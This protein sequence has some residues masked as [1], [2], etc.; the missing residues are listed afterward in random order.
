MA[1]QLCVSKLDESLHSAGTTVFTIEGPSDRSHLHNTLEEA[2]TSG[3]FTDITLIAKGDTLK[4]HRL[5]LK[6][7]CKN[8]V[9]QLKSTSREIELDLDSNILMHVISYVYTNVAKIPKED[10]RAVAMAAKNMGVYDLWKKCL[11]THLSSLVI[12][13]DNCFDMWLQALEVSDDNII[14]SVKTF[15]LENF[16]KLQRSS[17]FR[18]LPYKLL[19]DYITDNDL[20]ARN[21]D[22]RLGAALNWVRADSEQRSAKL[23][24]LLDALPLAKMGSWFL[25]HLLSDPLIQ[26][27]PETVEKITQALEGVTDADRQKGDIPAGPAANQPPRERCLVFVAAEIDGEMSN[28]VTAIKLDQNLE[29]VSMGRLEADIVG[30]NTKCLVVG[31]KLYSCGLGEKADEIWKHNFATRTSNLIAR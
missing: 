2:L 16:A 8:L 1:E 26:G 28:K 14:Q 25:D 3:E 5:I 23:T 22:E 15:S 9:E 13:N 27:I 24:F 21:N 4:L 11:S 18:A 30:S 7:Q 31:D 29:V 12:T 17:A 19:K 10:L 6:S 20:R